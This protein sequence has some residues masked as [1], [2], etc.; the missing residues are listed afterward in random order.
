[1]NLVFKKHKD[2]K[3]CIAKLIA[4]KLYECLLLFLFNRRESLFGG[5]R[6]GLLNI[7]ARKPV[8]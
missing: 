2:T 5:W 3:I 7:S 8:N 4:I 6:M 1:M